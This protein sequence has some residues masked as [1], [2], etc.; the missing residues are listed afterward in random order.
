MAKRNEKNEQAD[1]D[2]KAAQQANRD[3]MKQ[4]DAAAASGQIVT[5]ERGRIPYPKGIEEK[6]GIDP[7]SWRA[8]TDSVFPSAK[9]PE[10]VVLALAYC[11]ARRL[12]PFKRVIHIVPVW[13]SK[14]GHEVETVWPGIG[15]LR[16]TAH[17]T[18]QY[19]G[20][21]AAVFGPDKTQEFTATKGSDSRKITVTYPTWCQI[22]VY[23]MIEGQRVAFHGPRIQYEAS[24]G[25]WKGLPCPNDK[26]ARSAH[27]MLEKVAEAAA[28]RRAFPEEIGNDITAEEM[29]DRVIDAS[30]T[31]AS[32]VPNEPK[33]EDFSADAGAE[34]AD[35]PEPQIPFITSDGEEVL[36]A[37]GDF[38]DAFLLGLRQAA[39]AGDLPALKAA[40]ENN[41]GVAL[42]MLRA[43]DDGAKAADTLHKTY[44]ALEAKVTAARQAGDAAEQQADQGAAA[45]A[46]PSKWVFTEEDGAKADCGTAASFVA[47]ML[48]GIKVTSKLPGLMRVHEPILAELYR[49]DPD[50]HQVIRAAATDRGWV[51]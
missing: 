32:T 8:L 48:A 6:F 43:V 16:T 2:R 46:S 15:E 17:R 33:R 1:A 37:P 21:D 5:V 47:R 29:E 12:D 19:A 22:T 30:P 11:K 36:Y 42:T 44:T 27:Y 38:Y 45:G 4:L 9:T 35:E 49:V 3:R 20:N 39:D 28:L 40:W 51:E 18:G 25:M 13:D 14:K 10:A 24:Y 26:W 7:A 23:R 50:S 41:S 31:P 34:D